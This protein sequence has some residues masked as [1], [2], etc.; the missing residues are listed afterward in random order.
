[1]HY[2]FL[3]GLL[4]PLKIG[5]EPD[6]T[7]E[8]FLFLCRTNLAA[9]DLA[10]LNTLRLYYDIQN[11]RAF[12]LGESLDLMG[13]YDE[14]ALDEALL[15]GEGF[16]S[17]VY[18]FLEKEEKKEERLRYFPRLVA[19]FFRSEA[20]AATGFLRDIF[21][22]EQ[23]LRWVLI[24]FRAR[25]LHRDV[26]EELQDEDPDDDVV[27]QIIAQKDAKQFEPPEGYGEL[28]SL[29]REH[30]NDPMALHQALLKVK[31]RWIEERL[32][33]DTYSV[34]RVL[35]YGLQLIMVLKS[36]ELDPEKGRE[37]IGSL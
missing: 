26:I 28:K 1:M 21:R 8:E 24:G 29:F 10:K 34:D 6:I 13:N 2:Y 27:Y 7:W 31:F 37:L 22:F 5:E 12:W 20:L 25:R 11:I 30:G 9:A 3:V 35:G 16:P 15:T 17:Y 23:E 4:P 14:Q 33:N 19:T 36:M 32:V 18:Q